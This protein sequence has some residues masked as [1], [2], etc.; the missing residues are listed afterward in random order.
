V[1]LQ[2]CI[3]N[4]DLAFGRG[5]LPSQRIWLRL[6]C[7]G[8]SVRGLCSAD[9][10]VWYSVGQLDFPAD[11]QTQAGIFAAGNIDRTVYHG[12]YRDGAAIRFESVTI[13]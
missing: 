5:A 10:E 9:G 3:N 8:D 4:E 7:T 13:W 12:A 11:G 2:G 1:S 6:A